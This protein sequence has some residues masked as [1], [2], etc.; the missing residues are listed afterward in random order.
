[1]SGHLTIL[2]RIVAADS[3]SAATCT[4]ARGAS[5]AVVSGRTISARHS[6]RTAQSRVQ[7]SRLTDDAARVLAAAREVVSFA[8]REEE[9]AL[10]AS[11]MIQTFKVLERA[12]LHVP[13]TNASTSSLPGDACASPARSSAI[14][15][16]L[17]QLEPAEPS[18]PLRLINLRRCNAPGDSGSVAGLLSTLCA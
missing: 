4:C 17:A 12:P 10:A 15:S 6:H 16:A 9:L 18:E 14:G 3:R 2:N 5:S 1:M 13:S 11:G 7:R 8:L